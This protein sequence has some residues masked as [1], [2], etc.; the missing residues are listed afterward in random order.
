MLYLHLGLKS[1][2]AI[3]FKKFVLEICTLIRYEKK[4]KKNI[5][6]FFCNFKKKGN[7]DI[8]LSY[9]IIETDLN[10]TIC[11]FK[12]FHSRN[13]SDLFDNCG[14]YF[15]NL[16]VEY[17]FLQ[18]FKLILI[19]IPF[20]I[21][22]KFRLCNIVLFTYSSILLIC[23]SLQKIKNLIARDLARPHFLELRWYDCYFDGA[24][25]PRRRH[26]LETNLQKILPAEKSLLIFHTPK[27]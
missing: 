1:H 16:G 7:Y 10:D 25:S 5:Y 9:K 18:S 12:F 14:I 26:D 23:R 11:L 13:I 20:I 3:D 6:I 24:I 17:R 19:D 4:W 2:K 21:S 15:C 8:D 22:Q 27:N